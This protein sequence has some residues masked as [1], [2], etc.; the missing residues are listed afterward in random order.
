[1][2]R[3]IRSIIGAIAGVFFTFAFLQALWA[4]PDFRTTMMPIVEGIARGLA[5]GA[6]L[7]VVIGAIFLYISIKG[8]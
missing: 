5:I 2:E 6:V 4:I 3:T 7:F 8:R 1:M